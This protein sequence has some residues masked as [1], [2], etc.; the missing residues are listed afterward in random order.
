AGKVG[1][2]KKIETL[3]KKIINSNLIDFVMDNCC[4]L[5]SSHIKKAIDDQ[6]EIA[7]DIHSEAMEYIGKGLG[8]A[9]NMINP[10]RV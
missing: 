10:S 7:R 2:E 8:I 9:L 5:K 6:D 3:A 1:F 4:K